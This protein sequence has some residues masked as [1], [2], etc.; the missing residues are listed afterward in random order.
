MCSDLKVSLNSIKGDYTHCQSELDDFKRQLEE[1]NIEKKE[2]YASLQ[3]S[4]HDRQ[5]LLELVSYNTLEYFQYF[6]F[7]ILH[8]YTSILY[9]TVFLYR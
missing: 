5:R 9:L 3:D 6:Q 2:L 7:I 4:I 1:S 8:Y